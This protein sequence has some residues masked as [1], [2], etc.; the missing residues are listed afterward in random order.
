MT[1]LKLLTTSQDHNVVLNAITV[2]VESH[3]SINTE[4]VLSQ[5]PLYDQLTILPSCYYLTFDREWNSWRIMFFDT[6]E[7]IEEL[8]F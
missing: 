8:P 2:W 1:K 6:Y 3:S 7:T 4:P 5:Y